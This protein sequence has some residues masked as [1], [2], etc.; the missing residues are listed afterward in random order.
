MHKKV[1]AIITILIVTLVIIGYNTSLIQAQVQNSGSTTESSQEKS[2]TVDTSRANNN[3]DST[4]TSKPAGKKK[5]TGLSDL[6]SFWELTELGG[7][8]MWIIYLDFMVGLVII[9]YKIVQLV[10][11]G[12]RSRFILN[13]NLNLMPLE[14]I[15][16]TVDKSPHNMIKELF[17]ML[18]DVFETT[19]QTANFNEEISN[20]MT[21]QQDRF[22][23]FI[24]RL[25]FLSDTAGALGLLGTV[26]GMFLTFFGGNMDKQVIL[27]GMGVA[28]ITTIAGL[29]VS[30][31][32]NL[33]GTEIF[34]LFSR[35]LEHLQ[36]KSDE[37]RIRMSKIEKSKQ[38]RNEIEKKFL[39]QEME[40][41]Q[42]SSVD[43]SLQPRKKVTLGPPYKLV[44][45][46]GDGQGSQVNTRLKNP[47]VVEVLDAFENRLSGQLVKFSVEKGGGSLSNG[48]KVQEIF[49]DADGRAITYI[50][51]GTLAGDNI[52]R[53]SARGLDGQF[54]EFITQGEA[55]LPDS[56][57]LVSGNNLVG[58]AGTQ[59]SEPFVVEVKDGFMNPIPDFQVLFKMAMGNGFFA[60]KTT[61]YE[62]VTDANGRALAYFTLGSKKGFN[63]IVVTAKK[64]RRE[65]IEIQALGQ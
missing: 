31:I 55:S 15:A 11:D 61:K 46:A 59:L 6:G 13:S 27:D 28:L 45:V 47:F 4:L 57:V 1:S 53:T 2:V 41:S 7:D 62:V 51:T 12:Y 58:Q 23:T 34:S 26:W 63:R 50:T 52:V 49:T 29:V 3:S 22:K 8:I 43:D 17:E 39:E 16:E 19:G 35:R 9:I 37:F 54:V 10:A 44:Y 5:I 20:Y 40:I 24:A 30:M 64:L 18:I 38:K 21:Y 32:L 48:G 56:M 36:L 65:K 33:F 60:G 14:E 25:T 42:S